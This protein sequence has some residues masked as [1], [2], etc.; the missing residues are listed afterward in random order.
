VKTSHL[1]IIVLS[2][3]AGLWW[4]SER[5]A[6]ARFQLQLESQQR[7]TDEL[8]RLRQEHA[9]LLRMQPSEADLARLRREAAARE[10]QALLTNEPTTVAPPATTHALQP[11]IWAPATAWKNCGRK[12]PESALET[13]LWA[14][15]G[16]DLTALKETLA[17]DDASRAKVAAALAG[18]PESSRQQYT[19]P[20]D[21]L[22]LEVAGN[23]PLESAEFVARQQIGDDE[24]TEYVRL[25]DA[26]GVTRQVQL[27]LL[28]GAD[29]W[30]LHVPAA[31]VDE[32]AQ[33]LPKALAP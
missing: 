8:A 11:G 13:M 14:S 25:K 1:A 4:G 7:Q 2:V 3:A 15:A 19:T 33:S 24:A 27:T 26:A 28:R 18:L 16:G 32:I 20:E 5:S 10:P 6:A 29:G 21:L 9:R 22:A 31:T 30:K 23:V 17:F 12:T